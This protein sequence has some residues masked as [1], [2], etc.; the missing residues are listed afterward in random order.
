[1]QQSK[2]VVVTIPDQPLVRLQLFDYPQKTGLVNDPSRTF[3]FIRGGQAGQPVL[4]EADSRQ[5]E[6]E[7]KRGAGRGFALWNARVPG[8][9]DRGRRSGRADSGPTGEPIVLGNNKS[10]VQA[11]R[12]EDVE[13]SVLGQYGSRDRGPLRYGSCSC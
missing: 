12:K 4:S 5:P 1:M 9:D 2:T 6:L 3:V 8:P 10:Y 13:I 11:K 7:G